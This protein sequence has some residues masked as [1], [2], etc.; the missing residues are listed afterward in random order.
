M[1]GRASWRSV[2]EEDLAEAYLFLATQSPEAAERLFDP[3]EAAIDLLIENP[4]AGRSRA[5]LAERAQGVR[6]WA[7]PGFESFLLFYRP[8][9]RGID[10]LRLLHGARDLPRR[11][12]DDRGAPCPPPP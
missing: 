11:L 3:V 1:R 5:F 6:S 4:L 2:A 8:A 7:L 9:G 12:G 10:V